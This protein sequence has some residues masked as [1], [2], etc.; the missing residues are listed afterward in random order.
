MLRLYR[1]EEENEQTIVDL[2]KEENPDAIL[3]DGLDDAIIGIQR[4]CDALPVAAYDYWGCVEILGYHGMDFWEAVGYIQEFPSGTHDPVFIQLEPNEQR[5]LQ[6]DSN[7]EDP[8]D[9]GTG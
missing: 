3:I 7:H 1:P 4:K 6:D 8:F 2:L 9:T 5:D